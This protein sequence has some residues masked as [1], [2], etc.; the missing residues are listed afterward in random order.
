MQNVI[1]NLLCNR[2]QKRSIVLFVITIT[3]QIMFQ[4]LILTFYLIIDLR[5]KRRIQFAF[6]FDHITYD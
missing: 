2:Q 1:V 6:D 3:S 4:R 5:I